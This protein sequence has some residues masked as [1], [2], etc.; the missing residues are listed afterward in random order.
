MLFP[1]DVT[2][3]AYGKDVVD[4]NLGAAASGIGD[5]HLGAAASGIVEVEQ[6][7]VDAARIPS[8]PAFGK[9][10]SG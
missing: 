10:M 7:Q 4:N 8:S 3:N 9:V 5:N 2:G 6:T 1:N